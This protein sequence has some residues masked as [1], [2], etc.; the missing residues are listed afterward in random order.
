MKDKT[1]DQVTGEYLKKLID[2]YVIPG[3]KAEAYKI[4]HD[5]I[6]QYHKNGP[7]ISMTVGGVELNIKETK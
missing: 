2:E 1:K 6:Q 4:I 5:H 3:A 7:G